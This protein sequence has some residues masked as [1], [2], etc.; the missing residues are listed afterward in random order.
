MVH[1][2]ERSLY[3]LFAQCLK[4]S[5]SKYTLYISNDYI[6]SVK[7]TFQNLQYIHEMHLRLANERLTSHQ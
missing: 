3:Y 6:P 7:T 1:V 2:W 4:R 5:I